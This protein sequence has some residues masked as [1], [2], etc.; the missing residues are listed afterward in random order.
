[1]YNH[2]EIMDFIR[3]K[4]NELKLNLDVFDLE[5]LAYLYYLEASEKG[6][7]YVEK[8]LLNDDLFNEVYALF[9]EDKKN[10]KDEIIDSMDYGKYYSDMDMKDSTDYD[11][12]M[13]THGGYGYNE[14]YDDLGLD[15]RDENDTMRL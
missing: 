3:A 2:P 11:K 13:N 7:M 5:D 14:S 8:E 15:E 10:K 4:N 1:M 6:L 12:R 9:L